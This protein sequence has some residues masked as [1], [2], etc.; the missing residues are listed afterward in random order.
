MGNSSN[1]KDLRK[2]L[3]NVVLE[4]LP[5]LLGAELIR[6]IENRLADRI[7]PKLEA[8]DVRQK[9]FHSMIL[10]TYNTTA[11]AAPT[12]APAIEEVKAD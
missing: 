1:M 12:A 5:E 9:D 11:P 8:M 6:A 7:V 4:L 3:R 2:Q 10:R